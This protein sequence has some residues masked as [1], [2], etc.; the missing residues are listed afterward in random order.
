MIWC[1]FTA[2]L[3]FVDKILDFLDPPL[4]LVMI[5]TGKVNPNIGYILT[6]ICLYILHST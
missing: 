6:Y 1:N 3:F 4:S 2:I 5:N